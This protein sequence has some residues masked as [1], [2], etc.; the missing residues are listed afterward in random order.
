M[1]HWNTKQIM[2]DLAIII[3]VIA[4]DFNEG[5]DYTTEQVVLTLGGCEEKLFVRG[6]NLDNSV[7]PNETISDADVS[8]VELSDG[9]SSA[10]GLASKDFRVARAYIDVRQ[11]FI[12]RDFEVVPTMDAYF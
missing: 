5:E 1:A 11:Y 4:V 2:E 12:N 8:A 3:P 9:R 10:G 6:F 7:V